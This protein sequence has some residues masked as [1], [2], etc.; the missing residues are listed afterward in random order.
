[1]SCRPANGHSFRWLVITASIMLW[2]GCCPQPLQEQFIGDF[3]RIEWR[4]AKTQSDGIIVGV[5]HAIG[6]LLPAVEYAKS[7]SNNRSSK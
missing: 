4:N 7:I 6:E 1:M 5:P 2:S 3:A